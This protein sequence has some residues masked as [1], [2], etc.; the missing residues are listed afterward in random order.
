L[1]K[2]TNRKVRIINGSGRKADDLNKMLNEWEKAKK[3]M[4]DMAK[5]IKSGRNPF[6]GMF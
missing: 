6:G 3:K 1:K 2:E 4:D 5:Q